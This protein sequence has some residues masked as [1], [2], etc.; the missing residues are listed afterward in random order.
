MSSI[1][2]KRAKRPTTVSRLRIREAV[3]AV[4]AQ[5]TATP[6]SGIVVTITKK[7]PKKKSASKAK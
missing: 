7:S 3:S 4:Y 2:S 5:K 6:A 1:V